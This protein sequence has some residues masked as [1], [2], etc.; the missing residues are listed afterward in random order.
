MILGKNPGSI[1][2][3]LSSKP[4]GLQQICMILGLNPDS[5]FGILML[6]ILVYSIF[7]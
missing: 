2:G 3:P 5:V 1:F 7:A 4:A 6:Q